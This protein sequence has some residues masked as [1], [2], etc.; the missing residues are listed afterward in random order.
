MVVIIERGCE[1]AELGCGY[2]SLEAM[3][4]LNNE[5]WQVVEYFKIIGGSKVWN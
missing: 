1:R 5:G 4:Q 2:M 3:N